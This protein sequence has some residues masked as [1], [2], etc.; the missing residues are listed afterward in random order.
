M[1]P[2]PGRT[3]PSLTVTDVFKPAP[4]PLTV[5]TTRAS[6]QGPATTPVKKQQ[7]RVVPAYTQDHTPQATP[8]VPGVKPLI[9]I[10]LP[11]PTPVILPAA[12]LPPYG[13]P[14]PAA[15]VK[16]DFSIKMKGENKVRQYQW[17]LAQPG[18]AGENYIIVAPTGSGK[19]LVATMV[20]SN[21]LAKNQGNP[22]CHI[23]FVVNTKPLAEQ[24]KQQ[25]DDFIPAARVGAYTGD[26]DNMVANSIKEKN[27]ISVCTAASPCTHSRRWS[28]SE[29]DLEC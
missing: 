16:I 22:Q 17:E 20:I 15:Q 19:T 29:V 26:S 6:Q 10:A 21:H 2:A 8:R 5:D 23:V 9:P 12:N 3:G 4:P 18:I 28:S 1:P 24:Q 27:D 13:L 25:L 14:K 11:K 7:E